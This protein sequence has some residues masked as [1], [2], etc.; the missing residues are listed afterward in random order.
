MAGI[1]FDAHFDDEHRVLR[2]KLGIKDA[3]ELELHIARLSYIRV[4]ELE[5][6]PLR[7]KFDIPH[8]RAIH[9]YIFQDIFPWAGDF[10]EVTT[11]RTH[12]FGFPPPQ[13]L[14]PSLEAIF[15]ALKAEDHL[16]R[17]DA[18]TFARRAGHYLGEIN[19]V[20]PFREGNGRTQREFL[21]TLALGAGHRLTWAGLTPDENNTASRLSYAGGDSSALAALIRKRLL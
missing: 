3:A 18:D 12:S 6:K 16:K 4:I 11:S 10:R 2:N 21:R 17:L 5:T 7:G 19:A 15:A 1:L 9:R 20:H 14:V 13:F 8:L